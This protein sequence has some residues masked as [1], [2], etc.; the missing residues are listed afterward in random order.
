MNLSA[1]HVLTVAPA[2][3]PNAGA[4]IPTSLLPASDYYL[5]TDRWCSQLQLGHRW[6]FCVFLAH[7]ILAQNYSIRI[8]P[9]TMGTKDMFALII[10]LDHCMYKLILSCFKC[11]QRHCFPWPPRRWPVAWSGASAGV[12]VCMCLYGFASVQQVRLMFCA[13]CSKVVVVVCHVIAVE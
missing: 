3:L 2:P 5:L 7:L 9:R 13:L 10:R 1:A 6:Q 8:V 11:L 4:G 12:S